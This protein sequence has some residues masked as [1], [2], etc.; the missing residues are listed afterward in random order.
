M[1][2]ETL[3]F[4]MSALAKVARKSFNGR[5]TTKK[6]IFRPV[7]YITIAETDIRSLKSLHTLFD[8]YLDHVLVKYKQNRMFQTIQN[9]ELFNKK[10]VNH[11]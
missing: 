8:K 6:M 9:F 4:P 3:D 11:F 1:Y 5:F 10:M 2:E 7:F